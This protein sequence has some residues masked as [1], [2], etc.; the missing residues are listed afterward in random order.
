[1][2]GGRKEKIRE[3]G[4]QVEVFGSAVKV[5]E[6]SGVSYLCRQLFIYGA[7]TTYLAL[8][9]KLGHQYEYT[10][11]ALKRYAVTLTRSIS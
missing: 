6:K 11:S 10:T 9:H 7:L 8:Y 2:S 4:E 1:M 3:R 5:R